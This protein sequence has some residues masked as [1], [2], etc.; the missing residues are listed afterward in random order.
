VT[1][2]LATVQVERSDAACVVR[3]VGEIDLSNAAELEQRLLH[4][5]GDSPALVLDLTGVGFIDSSGVRVLDH[6]VTAFDAV[7]PVRVAAT[8]PGPVRMTLLLCGFDDSLLATSADDAVAALP[9]DR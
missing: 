9:A 4:E 8:D 6:L 3:V 5:A 1:E 7:R 2:S